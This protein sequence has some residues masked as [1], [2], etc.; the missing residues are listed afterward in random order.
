MKIL[1]IGNS[2][3]YY[4]DLPAIFSALCEENGQSVDTASV[5]KGGW[6]LHQY[7][8]VEN[9]YAEALRAHLPEE[10]DVIFL[11]EQSLLPVLEPDAFR[12]GVRRIKEA[13]GAHAKRVILYVTWGRKEGAKALEEHG[14]TRE[15]MTEGLAQAY[16]AAAR[17]FGCD[18]S[19]VGKAFLRMKVLAPEIDL[20][21]P[22]L[23]HPSRTGSC[24]AALVHYKTVFGALP[25]HIASLAL[26][27]EESRA[28][29]T[30]AKG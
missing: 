7:L 22:D 14:L 17:D 2:Y 30:A 8:D 1:F 28:L 15:S 23:T 29:L 27:E 25:K 19:P 4:N 12:D 13:F 10:F 20:Y 6:K 11:Q 26:S 5:T 16:E 24:L 9:E 21:H 3:T 18:F